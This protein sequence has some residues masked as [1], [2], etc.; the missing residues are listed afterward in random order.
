MPS[1]V[2][3]TR[4]LKVCFVVTYAYSLFNTATSF[5]FGGSEVRAWI[6][7][8]G[9]S[10]SQDIDVNFV[11]FNHKQPKRET[12]GNITVWRGDI[13]SP[14]QLSIPRNY[15]RAAKGITRRV[16]SAPF[17]RF[18]KPAAIISPSYDIYRSQIETFCKIDA[19]IYCVF[20]VH[21]V[22]A[23]VAAFCKLHQKRFVL[24]S[25]S[26][27]DFNDLYYP[28]SYEVSFYGN[29]GFVADYAIQNA[30]AIICQT[31]QQASMCRDKFG[32]EAFVVRNPMERSN[33]AVDFD[34]ES[35]GNYALW[36]GKSDRTKQPDVMLRLAA[37]CPD[38]SFIM[39]M[40]RSNPSL[41]DR[42]I[43]MQLPNTEIIEYTP[44]S[45]MENFVRNAKAFI[46]TSK[47]EG[48]PNTF[49]QAGMHGVPIASLVVDPDRFIEKYECGVS[50]GGSL[51]LLEEGL[52]EIW[53]SPERWQE[54]ARN[55][56]N[57][58]REN[59]DS[60]HKIASVREILFSGATSKRFSI[61][62][63]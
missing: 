21:H 8:V 18:E 56:T 2:K 59:H 33:N 39:V 20:G 48:F 62:R 29:V 19:D 61:T 41:H 43:K 23:E 49:L 58:V 24:F 34:L 31:E 37:R 63:L 6:F 50:A 32:R 42:I 47:F 7:G 44:F 52:K 55:V 45:E 17:K 38:I 5:P 40:T 54:C 4:P 12:F 9:L 15:W 14:N 1:D 30:D 10:E 27:E 26:D 46:S 11:V 53:S 3:G 28:G 57:Y 36:V 13:N 16:L 22:A 35:R 25:A 51:E 60:E